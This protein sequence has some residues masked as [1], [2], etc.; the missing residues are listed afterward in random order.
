[1]ASE[2]QRIE[3]LRGILYAKTRQYNEKQD[4]FSISFRSSHLPFQIQQ[5]VESL[6][7]RTRMQYVPQRGYYNLKFKSRLQLVHN[8]RSKPL[9]V[10]QDR[11]YITKI[12]KIQPQMCVHI[13]TDG[14]D[15]S[16]V[17]DEGFIACH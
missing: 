2:E 17:A 5:L 1:M 16:F 4:R 11:R 14:E 10:H 9:K 8:Q 3:L 6:G 15:G 12:T 13:E 7:M